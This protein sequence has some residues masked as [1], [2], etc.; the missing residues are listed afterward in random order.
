MLAQEALEVTLEEKTLIFEKMP[1]PKAVVKL[2]MP[3]VLSMLVTILYNMVDTYFVGQTG[4]ANQVAAVSLATPVFFILMSIGNMFG[5]GGGSYI[6]RL[7]GE[8][9]PEKAKYVSSFS[10]YGA[11]VAGVI[12]IGVFFLGMPFILKLIGSDESTFGFTGDY[13]RWIS[14]GAPFVIISASSPNIVRSEGSAKAAMAGMMIGTVTNIILDPIMILTLNMGAGGAAVATT[15]GNLF[16][17]VYYVIYFSRSKTTLSISPKDFKMSEGIAGTVFAIGVPASLNNLLMTA[18][19]ILMNNLLKIYGP[20]PIAGMGIAFKAG[21]LVAM[22][23]IGIAMGIQPLIGYSYGA[24]DFGRMKAVIRFALISNLVVG[25]V[26]SAVYLI[27]TSSIVGAFIADAAVI[28][29]GTKMLRALMLVGPILGVLFVSM[30]S[31]QAMGKS[32]SALVLSI[33]RQGLVFVPVLFLGNALF[34]LDGVIYA[35]PIA[36]AGSVFMAIALFIRINNKIKKQHGEQPGP[37]L[38]SCQPAEMP[39]EQDIMESPVNEGPAKT[40]MADGSAEE[41]ASSNSVETDR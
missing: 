25:T 3:T 31:F 26:L 4:D 34:G 32:V 41:K 10:F 19:N 33:S 21:S 39:P 36:D 7:L 2:A 11:L 38:A 6:S 17:A 18:S 35:S 5:I 1:V 29:I 14:V 9:R 23:Q 30:S 12:M 13:L 15:I 24:R 40:D 8:K 28:E 20:V 22:L 37:V 27:F 16:S